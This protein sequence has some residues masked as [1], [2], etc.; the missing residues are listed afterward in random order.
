MAPKPA[1]PAVVHLEGTTLEGGGQLLRVAVGLASLTKKAINIT[2]IRGK[3]SGGGGLKT[4]HLTSVLWLGQA[5]SARLSGVGLKSKELTFKPKL[6][7]DGRAFNLDEQGGEV[8]INQSTPGSINLVLQATLPYILFS[9]ALS[10]VRLRIAG[11]TNVSYSPSYDYILEVLIPMLALIG[12]PPIEAKLH[13]RGWSQGSTCI[14]STT[15]TITPLA[16]K[17]P[18]FQLIDRGAIT[19]IKAIVLA[20][21]GIEQQ[22]R[23]ELAFMFEKRESRFFGDDFS[24]GTTEITFED[25]HHEKR[26]YLLLVATSDR[27]V[28][29]GRDWLYDQAVRPGKTEKI[30]PTMVKKVS[31]DLL[32][33]IEHGGCVDEF[34][35]DQLVVFQSLAEGMSKVFEGRKGDVSVQPSLHTKTAMWVANQILGVEFDEEGG[36]EGMGFRPGGGGEEEEPTDAL[37]KELEK[38]EVDV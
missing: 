24:Q 25:S 29:L 10:P 20:P 33:E 12:L 28:K 9:G 13:S 32:M 23:D 37:A 1:A 38:L 31:D 30:I 36:C 7:D 14:G 4:Q 2:N 21:R 6:T 27:G 16:T 17:L 11:G 35:R 19:H 34:M 18:A 26:Y 15:Y 22:F 3:R 5:C 8:R